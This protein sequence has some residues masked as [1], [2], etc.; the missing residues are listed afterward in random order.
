MKKLAHCVNI[1]LYIKYFLE[2]KKHLQIASILL[3][4]EQAIDEGIK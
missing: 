1:Y 3:Y 4:K 2:N